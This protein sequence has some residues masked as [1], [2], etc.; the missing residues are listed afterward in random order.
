VADLLR[1][2]WGRADAFEP[3]FTTDEVARWP[4]GAFDLLS[5]LGLLGRAGD[6]LAIACDACGEDHVEEVLVVG[7]RPDTNI[8]AYIFCPEA[9]RVAVP[10]ERLRRWAID[11]PRL[12]ALTS[13]TLQA[14]G[15]VERIVP[16]RIWLLGRL[17]IGG[18]VHE[19]FFARGLCWPDAVEVVGQAGRLLQSPRR[20]VLVPGGVP[21]VDVW[22]GDAPRILPLSALLSWDGSCLTANH[23]LLTTC[24]AKG[25]KRLPPQTILFPTPAGATWEDVHLTVADHQVCVEVKGVRRTLTFQEAGFEERR[26]GN[27]PNRLWRLLRLMALHGGI[28]S[29][30]S[31]GLTQAVRDNLKQYVN[32]LGQQLNKLLHIEGR[33]IK[34]LR[35]TR[36]YESRFRIAAEGGMRFPTPAGVTW[37][38]VSITETATGEIAIAVDAVEPFATFV[39]SPNERNGGRWEG[40]QRSSMLRREYD[41]RTLG[42]AD[43][44]GRPNEAGQALLAVLRGGGKVQREPMDRAM[45]ALGR[46]LTDLLAIDDPPFQFAASRKLWTAHFEASSPVC[47]ARS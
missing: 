2:L 45:L 16:C 22:Q 34:L 11:F 30:D 15:D 33:P 6:A 28:I 12:A 5:G 23:S 36:R 32:Q 1:L 47:D 43:Q 18:E 19:V 20:L 41:L 8:R 21:P 29:L 42:L 17:A 35:R 26:R 31:P 25:K 7:S 27:A 39:H 3:F 14:A 9:G 13:G 37:D 4:V 24:A 10:L 46:H 44:T 38:G 40:A